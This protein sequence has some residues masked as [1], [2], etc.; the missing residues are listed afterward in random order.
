LSAR[1]NK[2]T[3]KVDRPKLTPEHVK[4]LKE[5]AAGAADAK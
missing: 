5:A 3:I 2:L 4:K 1:L